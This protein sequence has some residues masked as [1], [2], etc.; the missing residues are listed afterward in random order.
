VGCRCAPRPHCLGNFAQ[1]HA[2]QRL[3]KV[4]DHHWAEVAQEV[5]VFEA[6]YETPGFPEQQLAAALASKVRSVATSP[7]CRRRTA[8]CASSRSAGA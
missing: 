7:L 5:S 1:V 6:L 4:V 2:L 8:L 3:Y